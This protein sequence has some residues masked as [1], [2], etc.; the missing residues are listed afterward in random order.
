MSD[1]NIIVERWAVLGLRIMFC[2]ACGDGHRQQEL[3]LSVCGACMS[4]L[5]YTLDL[6]C[7][8]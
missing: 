2:E 6:H 5:R 7:V 4:V 1:W 3:R 8:E